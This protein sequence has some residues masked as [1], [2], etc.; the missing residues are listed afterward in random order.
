MAAVK[1]WR[2]QFGPSTHNAETKS[3]FHFLPMI[4][5][6]ISDTT[7]L[8][9]ASHRLYGS[10]AEGSAF[11]E[12]VANLLPQ[13]DFEWRNKTGSEDPVSQ[14][15]INRCPPVLIGTSL[16]GYALLHASGTAPDD[17]DAM[18]CSRTNIRSARE[19]STFAA[20]QLLR[21]LREV[22]PSSHGDLDED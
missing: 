22:R 6:I 9:G 2:L 16:S 5:M 19:Y 13:H 21:N 1:R 11:E 10:I 20:A 18:S 3:A 4:M 12:Q 17:F 8:T 15:G 14:N 7:A